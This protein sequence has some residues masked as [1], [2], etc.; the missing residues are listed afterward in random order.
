MLENS[1]PV[2]LGQPA[3]LD[4]KPY[5]GELPLGS[6]VV[7]VDNIHHDVYLSPQVDRADA[8][9]SAGIAPPGHQPY[10]RRTEQPGQGTAPGQGTVKGPSKGPKGPEHGAWKRQLLELLQASLTNAKY[11]KKIENDLLL[12]VAVVK[13]LSQE[14]GN[15]FSNLML[16]AKE[17]IRNRGEYYERSEQAHVMKARLAEL[18][19]E[20][21]QHFLRGWPA[22]LPGPG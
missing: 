9:V 11:G 5:T 21:A 10:L 15:Q 12:R 3:R 1:H 22:R 16:E 19:A 20:P 18:Q 14:I 2:D 6:L 13:F 17:W 7:G 8:H 4:L